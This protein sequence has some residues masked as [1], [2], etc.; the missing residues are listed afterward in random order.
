MLF[1]KFLFYGIIFLILAYF[2]VGYYV[3]V[4]LRHKNFSSAYD[5]CHKVWSARGLYGGEIDENSIQSI[6][7]AFDRGAMGVEVDVFYDVDM[8]DFIVSHNRPYELKNGKILPLKELFDALGKDHYFWLDFKK[9]RHLSKTQALEAVERLKEISSRNHLFERVYVEGENPTN[10]ALFRKAGFHTIF[11][12]HP[13]TDNSFLEPLMIGVY[14]MFYYFGEHTV[15]GMEYG[16]LDNPVFGPNTQRRLGNIPV[17]LYH[18]PVDESLVD[19]LLNIKSVRA[20]IV[21]NNQ[22]VDFHHKTA[23]Q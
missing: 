18:V 9:L 6:G 7:K 16:E 15:M 14:K 3:D 20:F 21:G 12:T 11:D 2:L 5:D 4:K 1:L 8:K 13:A 17:F 23:C 19:K 10:L 22:S